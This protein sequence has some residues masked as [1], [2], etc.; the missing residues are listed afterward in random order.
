MANYTSTANV[1]LSVNGKQAQQMLSSLEKNAKRLERQ[2]T[3][4]SKAGDKASMK[5]LQRELNQTNRLMDQLKGASASTER[6]LSRLD[7]ATPKELNKALRQLKNELNGIERGTAAWDAQIAKIKAVRAEIDNVNDAMR[8]G[9][10]LSDR[11]AEWLNKWQMALVAVGAAITGLVM[12]G[13]KAV[14]A[15]AEMEQEMANV[16]KFTGMEADEVAA[17]NEEFKKVDTRTSREE[18]NQLAQEI[19]RDIY[20]R[21]I[22]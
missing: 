1:I 15:Y 11:V 19:L 2:I 14:N 10:S 16:R 20:R 17:R 4:A 13:R 12:A 9:D 3:A 7:K 21:K 6:I 18:L 5:K 22:G 8:E